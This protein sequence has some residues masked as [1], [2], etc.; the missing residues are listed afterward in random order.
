M[1]NYPEVQ[2]KVSA[3]IDEFVKLNGRLP[4]FSERTELPYCVSVLKECMRFKPT[5]P[6]GLPHAVHKD[7]VYIINLIQYIFLLTSSNI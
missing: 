4:E 3:E 7:G 2:R 6:F 1:C 5:T